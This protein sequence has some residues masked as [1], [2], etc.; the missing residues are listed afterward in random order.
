MLQNKSLRLVTLGRLTLIGATGD[1]DASLAKR[2]F[3]LALLA[4]LAMARRPV[5]RDTLI[6]MFWP[7]HDEA[8]AR[9]CLSN[10]LSSLR[11]SLGHGAIT[12][13]DANVA[14]AA[15]AG[16]VVDALEMAEAT[17]SRDAARVV[18]LY[19]G[20]FLDGVRVDDS[21]TFEH[22]TS[23]ERRR[24]EALFLKA[25][26]RQCESLA[27]SR[28]W[29]ECHALAARW[30]DVEPLS[31]DAA[32]FLINA[33]KSDGTRAALVDALEEYDRLK[34]RLSRDFE[35]VPEPPVRELAARIRDELATMSPMSAGNVTAESPV[36]RL[37][38]PEVR[39]PAA[40]AAPRLLV[41][42]DRVPA[43]NSA[44][45]SRTRTVALAR[46][47]RTPWASLR[48]V[49]ASVGG[50]FALAGAVWGA[51]HSNS[52]GAD[53][54]RKPAV[55]VLALH[56]PSGDST[57]AW[58]AEGLPAMIAGKLARSDA[59]DVVPQAR[60]RAVIVRSGRAEHGPFD[61]GVARDLA[62]RVGGT[63]EAHGTLGR[64]GEN[65]VLDLAVNDV[66]V[67]RLLHNAVLTRASALALADEAAARIL[68][69]ANVSVPG[70]Q[71]AG[72][73]TSSVEAY[74]HYMRAL[75]VGNAGRISA[76]KRE[77]DA[78]IALDSGFIGVVRARL[79]AAISENDTV[80]VRRLRET[81][82]RHADR[83]TEFD[84]M[85][86]ATHD[87]F[88]SGERERSEALARGLVRRYPRDPRA[89]Q[90][91][92]SVLNSHGEF[93][94]AERVAIQGLALD[95]LAMDAGPGP[96]TP[97]L[98]FSTIVNARW[99]AGD[100]PGAANW[101]RRW[102]RT[103]PDGASAWA[104]LAWTFSYMQRPDSALPLMQRALSLSGGELWATN[105]LARMLMV[106]RRYESADSIVALM[107]ARPA[108]EW[109]EAAF[110]LRVLLERERGW[111][112]AANR[113]IDRLTRE[114][115]GAASFGEMVRADNLRLLGDHSEAAR[116]YEAPAH[117]PSHVSL[118][119]PI[120]STSARAFCWHH[121]LAADAYAPTGDTVTLRA[122]ADTLEAGCGRS[123]Y[124]RDW[125]LYHHVRGLVALQGGRFEEAERELRLA[126]WTP[127]EGW[128]RTLV[129]LANAQR[130]LGRPADAIASL[131]SGYATRL[132]AMGRY[133]PISEL[134]YW[135]A[136][137]FADAGRS[138]SARVYAQH[139]Q[140]AWKDADPEVR[141]LLA[142]LP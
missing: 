76:H 54:A 115:P 137:A 52:G 70:P 125:R 51:K 68:N 32:L 20:P 109:R 5:P 34:V 131:R 40:E 133:V 112:R 14:L 4:V 26:A 135:M 29:A 138:D 41:P 79:N 120:A 42:D 64:D 33:T 61:D 1:E 132:D 89:Y 36:P 91:L 49:A 99:L 71:F 2:R 97:C 136:L 122:T 10:A 55:A 139:V 75:E 21:P 11:R 108:R 15:D 53:D 96:C 117:M 57:I 128:A 24:I 93:A 43:A 119:L 12:T 63:I 8:R 46:Q 39:A 69:V 110:D 25:C 37:L 74:E 7:E 73:E 59:I 81:L 126:I 116:R 124:G 87:A 123:F 19:A 77:L 16:L 47:T 48:V 142:R 107:S 114:F 80:V 50:V 94:E 103:Q 85:H 66:R 92:Q 141:R 67:G 111:V 35:L 56:V 17:E 58:L 72:L 106:A 129:E 82:T 130:A 13:R 23:R 127:A 100:F 45:D 18:E 86:Q 31:A 113:T 98:G 84:R 90:L 102:I 38:P 3:K 104:A 105:E 62:R 65:L 78:A 6:A 118:R 134:D 121:A 44:G 28:R 83:A 22:W 95:S 30:L 140:H 101:A 9:H 27:R 60:V 88:V